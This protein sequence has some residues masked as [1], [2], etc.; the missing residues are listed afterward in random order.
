MRCDLGGISGG[1]TLGKLATFD[2]RPPQNIEAERAVLGAMLLNREAIDVAQNML[3]L[4][5]C[6]PFW[7]EAHGL[8]FSA[9]MALHN[10][11]APVDAVTLMT[12][13]DK[14]GNLE[15]CGGAVYLAELTDAVPSSANVAHYAGLVRE[16]AWLRGMITICTRAAG[17][18]YNGARD[19]AGLIDEASGLLGGLITHRGAS[20]PV[21]VG[22]LVPDAVRMLQAIS[23]GRA[24][25]GL[26]TGVTELDQ[27]L[28]G[29][30]REDF[31]ILAAA[32]SVGKTALSIKFAL[33]AA[34][35]G[36]RVLFFSAEMNKEKIMQ[37][38]LCAAGRID[39]GRLRAGFLARAELP[40]LAEV[41]PM[42]TELPMDIDD[43]P[44]PSVHY[45]KSAARQVARREPIDLV[46]VD[47]IQLL[48]TQEKAEN[49]NIELGD[50]SRALKNLA[51]ELKAAVIGLSQINREGQKSD[52]PGLYHLRDSGA[53]EADAD[54][55]L[56]VSRWELEGGGD[57]LK[58]D[59]KKQRNGPTGPVYA[60]FVK[61]E[62][63]IG[64]VHAGPSAPE[65]YGEP[66]EDDYAEDDG[67]F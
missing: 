61:S 37:R 67:L 4:P 62:Q 35:A 66:I 1:I 10:A 33:A 24:P 34:R 8:I 52:S 43:S 42:V 21:G 9:V 29:L 41:V 26:P 32:P 55:V 28:C 15:R 36:Y 27:K 56:M 64:D 2:R 60:R 12:A 58:I 3:T 51:R 13:L 23:E 31:I 50:I 6:E 59:V 30:Q 19:A 5:G 48:S 20:G 40:K 49:R 16:A 47:Y 46:V 18:G 22:D 57:G 25:K 39:L 7:V 44:N 53:L 38:L 63:W 54:V 17:E 14:A 11:G 45:I 65:G